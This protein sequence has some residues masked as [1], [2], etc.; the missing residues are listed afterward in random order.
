MPE[1]ASRPA[2]LDPSQDRLQLAAALRRDR[3]DLGRALSDRLRPCWRAADHRVEGPAEIV[4]AEC[5]RLPVVLAA[6]VELADPWLLEDSLDWLARFLTARGYAAGP[7]LGALLDACAEA[8]R[9][10]GPPALLADALAPLLDAARAALP[11][12]EPA[13]QAADAH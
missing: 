7:I 4:A 13:P 11:D 3:E 1:P 2:P 5:A 8:T 9:S 12:A 6:C 10:L